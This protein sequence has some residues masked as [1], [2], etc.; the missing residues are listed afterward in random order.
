[1]SSL[2][3][4]IEV[5]RAKILWVWAWTLRELW[6]LVGF[7]PLI[8]EFQLEMWANP[9]TRML[10]L[11]DSFRGEPKGTKLALLMP[12]LNFTL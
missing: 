3:D 9:W 8:F 10:A 2:A 5:T 7:L 12:G 11:F 6:V 1:M 4:L